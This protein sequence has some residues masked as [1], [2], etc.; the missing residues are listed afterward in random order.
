MFRSQHRRAFTL[1]ELLVVIAIIAILIG[2]LLPAV[3][4][5]RAAAARMSCSNNVK[6]LGIAVHTLNDAQNTLPP[7]CATCADPGVAGCFTPATTPFGSHIYTMFA[8]LMPYIE[9]D[10]IYRSLSTGGY[11]GGQYF[12]PVKTYLCP[13]DPS[14]QNGLNTTS[15]G[16][17]NNW[18]AA[19][20]GGNVYVFGDPPTGRP[21]PM[22]RK[23][24][25]ASVSDG[26][27]NT[28]FFAEMYGTCGATGD[29]N[30]LHGSLWA[31][32][33]SEW[34]PG[35]NFIHG[36]IKGSIS[37]YGGNPMFQ[38]NPHYVNNCDA[39]VPQGSHTGGIMVGL[40]DGSV[41]FLSGSISLITWQLATDPR[42]GNPL[43]SNW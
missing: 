16:G 36:S 25:N 31:D 35:F 20:Y 1:I 37:N 34:R 32:S 10:N 42:D 30:N 17:A 28:V 26:L 24:M 3:Q 38:I 39:D 8:F 12:R 7:L 29:I 5:V 18:G 13:S 9:Q 33:N 6:Q 27:S 14:V 11:A 15:R 21:F 40:G 22:G 41:R 43:G 4:K 2:L 19:C 23:D